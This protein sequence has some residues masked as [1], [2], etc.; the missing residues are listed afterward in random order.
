MSILLL[1][2]AFTLCAQK[3]KKVKPSYYIFNDKG[4]PC[5]AEDARYMGIL[6]K[7]TDSAYQWKYYNFY[8]SLISIETY[9]D[10]EMTI[11]HGYYSF[12]DSNGN[13]DSAGYTFNGRKDKFWYYY[14]DSL[15]VWQSEEYNKGVL[16]ERLDAAALKAQRE[17]LKNHKDSTMFQS[18]EKEANFKGAV[19]A[20]IKYLQS[21]INF[22]SRAKRMDTQG[23]VMVS[24]VVDKDGSINDIKIVQSVEYSLDEEAL[25][26]IRQSPKWEP[27]F[28]NG[29]AVRAYRRQPIIFALQ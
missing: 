17:N 28:Q 4:E 10:K 2:S 26:L 1:L 15:T 18:V 6:E 14:S 21:N 27:A 9:N 19:E 8:G 24:F 25:R 7:L 11:P 13:I 20:W 12:F 3:N 29:K 16:I 22:P 5:K 23:K